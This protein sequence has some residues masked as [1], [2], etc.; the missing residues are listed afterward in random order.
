MSRT[1]LD[2]G[3]F[4]IASGVLETIAALA[5]SEVD[6]VKEVDG[7]VMGS[8]ASLGRKSARGLVI[9]VEDDTI[10]ADV[11]I[12]VEHETVIPRVARDVQAKVTR[13][14]ESMTGLKV[15]AVDV[16]VRSLDFTPKSSD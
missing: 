1:E 10:A 7:G 3:E 11:H 9:R 4:R 15:S 14:L 12:V 13:A 16:H 5:I 8:I 6:G 2:F